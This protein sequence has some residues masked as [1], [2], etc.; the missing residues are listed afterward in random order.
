MVEAFP[1]ARRLNELGYSALVLHYRAG[2]YAG[3]EKPLD[4]LAC[5][6]RYILNNAQNL[7]SEPM[8]TRYAAILRRPSSGVLWHRGI[9]LEKI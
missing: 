2:A 3:R 9:R 8:P 6:V 4:D 5:A 7:A 1:S